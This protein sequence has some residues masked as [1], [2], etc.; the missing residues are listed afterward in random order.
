[1]SAQK[2]FGIDPALQSQTACL[3]P[4]AY[5][6]FPALYGRS[7]SY[8]PRA[9]R[10]HA[11]SPPAPGGRNRRAVISDKSRVNGSTSTASTWVCSSN[12]SL[13]GNGVSSLGATSGRRM[14]KRMRLEGH[15]H[16]FAPEAR[17]RAPPFA[18]HFLMRAMHAVEVAHADHGGTEVRRNIIEIAKNLHWRRAPRARTRA[19]AHRVTGAHCRVA[20]HWSPRAAD[21]A[22]CA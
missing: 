6:R 22:R 14:R 21:H 12:F 18:D 5:S 7:G 10:A 20:R 11:R 13:A 2:L 1:M 16:G 9:P 15:H 4:P 8:S 19:S 3:A 17:A